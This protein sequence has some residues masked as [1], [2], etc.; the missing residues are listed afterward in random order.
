MPFHPGDH[1]VDHI[2]DALHGLLEPADE[3]Y[4]RQH[5]AACPICSVALAEAKRRLALLRNLSTP[6]AAPALIAG[7]VSKIQ[8]TAATEDRRRL[9][10]P[11][12]PP[13]CRRRHPHSRQLPPLADQSKTFHLRPPHPRPAR[14]PL[15]RQCLPSAPNSSTTILPSPAPPSPSP[16]KTRT[17]QTLQLASYTTDSAGTGSPHF[18]LPDWPDG[19]YTLT[20]NATTGFHTESLTETITL[21]RAAK[22]MLSTDKPVY[23][24]GQTMHIRALALRRPDQKPIAA[25]AALFTLTDPA[26]NIILKQPGVTSAYGLTSLDCP[27][28]T[29][30]I[31]GDYTINCRIGSTDS[32][33]TV[34]VKHYTLPKFK[35][36]LSTDKPFYAPGERV[37]HHPPGRLFL[38]PACRQCP[39]R[40]HRL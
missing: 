6:E 14:T 17:R 28:A 3:H 12:D 8:A 21:K 1:V 18:Q 29:E 35:V 13:L 15:R 39:C 32:T 37:P 20:T 27:L 26:G 31:E 30:I 22:I 4:V 16:S 11:L 38:R 40:T 19:Q 24:P 33:A 36:T 7:V 9:H 25:Q 10:P 2:D 34:E 23:Q 5:A